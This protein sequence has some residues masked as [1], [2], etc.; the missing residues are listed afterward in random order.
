MEGYNPFSLE[1]KVIVIS[2][3]TSGVGKTAAE[4]FAAQGAKIVIGGRNE[5]AAADI[6]DGVAGDGS[7]GS[8]PLWHCGWRCV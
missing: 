1:G 8:V 6:D 7:F 4:E 2:G 3:G 5:E